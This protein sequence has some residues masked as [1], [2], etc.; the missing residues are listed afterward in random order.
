M[1]NFY[2]EFFYIPKYGKIR[3][4]VMLARIAMTVVII[5]GCLA[6]MGITAYAYFSYNVTSGIS[7]IK[8][9]K[10]EA[11]VSIDNG[12]VP[13]TDN[14]EY[15]TADLKAGTAY[16]VTLSYP[17]EDQNAAETGFCVVTADNCAEI[18]HTQQLGVD[19]SVAGEWTPSVTFTLTV[20]K[21]TTVHILS[22][23]GTS[24]YYDQ[25][26]SNAEKPSLYILNQAEVSMRI[27]DV[28]AIS[29]PEEVTAT[30]G[31][32]QTTPA[33]VLYTVQSGDTLSKI[34]QAYNT[35][36]EQI[37][38]YNKLTDVNTIQTGLVL[39]IP[40]ADATAPT[41]STT[42]TEPAATQPT[43]PVTT[44]ATDAPTAETT[45]Q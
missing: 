4:K 6:A 17:A 27:T 37:A 32:A 20:S 13:V 36:V 38:A 18:Y 39:K 7:V 12:A 10:F 26:K 41:D 5:V 33:E 21:D 24:T 19:K 45:G 42:G 40:P 30:E 29:A 22:H 31:T 1:R 35:T 23:L 15:H 9:A 11:Q 25:Y 3:E 43:E 2:N 8:A 34:A 28:P 14:G 16:S 44:E